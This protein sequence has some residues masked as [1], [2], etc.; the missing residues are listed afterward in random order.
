[1]YPLVYHK[2]LTIEKWSKYSKGQQILMIANELNRAGNRINNGTTDEVNLCYERAMELTDLTSSDRKWKNP[3][4]K[5]LRRFRETLGWLYADKNKDI[6]LNELIYRT[7]IQMNA[8]AW[9]LL[10][11]DKNNEKRQMKNDHVLDGREND[12]A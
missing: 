9:N 10:G 7:L 11:K 1:M 3:A 12:H 2:K 5:E 4:L 8:E 6:R